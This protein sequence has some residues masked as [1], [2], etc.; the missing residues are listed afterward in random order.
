MVVYNA[1]AHIVERTQTITIQRFNAST[2]KTENDQ[3]NSDQQKIG[4]TYVQAFVYVRF[5][6]SI[7]TSIEH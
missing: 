5:S 6:C 2:H 3:N 1:Y 4:I 7:R